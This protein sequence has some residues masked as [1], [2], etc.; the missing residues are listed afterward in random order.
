[1]FDRI[2]EDLIRGV[3]TLE[4]L[5]RES[6]PKR[7]TEAFA[8]IVSI[9]LR[10]SAGVS[11]GE[12]E[13]KQWEDQ[14]NLLRRLANTYE[15]ITCLLSEHDEHRESCAFVAATAHQLLHRAFASDASDSP[16]LAL[17]AAGISSQL[18]ALLLFFIAG[19][20]PD[21]TETAQQIA[22][23]SGD[24]IESLL[25]RA[26]IAL[27]KGELGSLLT[28]PDP[29]PI[30]VLPDSL[31]ERATELLWRRLYYG[32]R[33][34][35]S[36]LLEGKRASESKERAIEI[37]REVEHLTV[38]RLD[39][40]LLPPPP[41]DGNPAAYQVFGGP[42]HLAT[43]LKASGDMLRQRAVT[44]IA[45]PSEDIDGTAWNNLLQTMAKTRPCLWP[46]HLH[47]VEAGFLAPGTSATISF[48]TGAGKST[49]VQLKIAATLLRRK[50]T[51][52]L[53]PTHA[54][55]DQVRR[56]LTTVF[57]GKDVNV[58][59]LHDELEAVSEARIEVMTPEACLARIGVSRDY[60][61]SVGLIVFDE[62]HLLH[63]NE[64]GGDQRSLDAMLCLLNLLDAGP[65]ADVLLLSAMMAN[66]SELA[67]WL[68]SVAGR[69]CLS[70]ELDWKPTRQ[71][72][73]CVVYRL[74]DIKPLKTKLE[75]ARRD[76]LR[77]ARAAGKK[78]KGKP[79]ASIG[80]HLGVVPYGLF[81]LR[82]TWHT[83][84]PEDYSLQQILGEPVNL[85][86]G[87][88]NEW[89]L[90]ANRNK[91]SA[92]L[93]AA[94]GSSGIKTMVLVQSPRDLRS[95][96]SAAAERL[97]NKARPVTLTAE[98]EGLRAIAAEELGEEAYVYQPTA[99]L[100]AVHHGT[101]LPAERRLSERLF[102][103]RDGVFILAV[104]PTLS[105][106]VNLPA[107]AI[108]I[109]GDDRYDI[110]LDKR[111][112][113]PA[114]DLLNAAGRAGRAGSASLGVV[115]VVPGA[116]VSFDETQ[117]QIEKRWFELQESVFSKSDQCLEIQDPLGA[118]LDRLQSSSQ[119]HPLT[120]LD[121]YVLARLPADDDGSGDRPRRF[122]S[123]SLAAY[124]ASKA[125]RA[126]QYAGLIKHVLELRRIHGGHT[127]TWH[128]N[129]SSATGFPVSIIRAL[130]EALKD[131]PGMEERKVLDWVK[132]WF[133]WLR[134][135]VARAKHLIGVRALTDLFPE[136]FRPFQDGPKPDELY[137]QATSALEAVLLG[138]MEGKPLCELELQFN[139]ASNRIG[140]CD[141]ARVFAV[142]YVRSIGYAMDLLRRVVQMH[143]DQAD[144]GL[145]RA[146]PLSLR[147]LAACVR[148]GFSQ[149]EQLAIFYLTGDDGA[150][151]RCHRQYT[152]IVSDILPGSP[153][154]DFADTRKRVLKALRKQGR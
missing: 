147:T 37:F 23:P 118:W 27:A 48:P 61:A 74:A 63:P 66:A 107:E 150:R 8:A 62:C 16:L 34:L 151:V 12:A 97:G 73:G 20:F 13:R 54:L 19:A 49:V 68:S 135:D 15:T 40:D 35:A 80:N 72:R 114:H 43:L 124:Q 136:S 141:K 81:C 105:Q 26:L 99:G 100:V 87:G 144:P 30:D 83:R 102:A 52:F 25:V 17:G 86:I 88:T 129:M 46:N 109:A 96:A 140:M 28:L 134:R 76:A 9:R 65:E 57:P 131:E 44:K 70:L 111:R 153:T 139:G 123:R 122:L 130:D 133:G 75:S 104:S 7:L 85:G 79:S 149:P 1:M 38:A 3:P 132:W 138:W 56:D 71:A 78:W 51:I 119:Q 29:S 90:T 6:L 32:I 50:H 127:G 93:A 152:A 98:E 126:D 103:R 4:G 47:A 14:T 77:D 101:L 82:Q 145:G 41:S 116:V 36:E 60:F 112:R 24:R 121:Q 154:E 59:A 106:G 31:D 67:A 110:K 89:K 137:G 45:P 115:L 143:I 146:M 128:D 108:I 125:E 21:A 22:T 5:D 58:A 55:V 18:A 117:Q 94:F 92:A 53:V 84:A 42:H 120:E 64:D 39:D 142:R 11:L 33:L 95:L 10:W 148:E 69:P 2:T 113:L 91:V